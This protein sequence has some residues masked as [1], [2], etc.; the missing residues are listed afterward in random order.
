MTSTGSQP[1]DA[2]KP[3]VR[4]CGRGDGRN[5]VT[6]TRSISILACLLSVRVLAAPNVIL[7][8]ADDMGWAQT[9]Y[10]DHPV[11]ETP[12]LDAMAEN[13]LRMDRFY[14]GAPQ[15]STTRAT[16]LTGRTNDR[17]GVLTVGSSINKQEK[18]LSAA[19]RNA[20][21]TTAHFGKWHLN[22]VHGPDGHP[23]PLSDPHHPGELGFDYWLSE[24][25]QFNLNPLLSRNGTAEHIEGESS[26]ILV[27]E[28]LRFI[29]Q[30]HKQDKPAFVM[31]WYAS[32]HR[33]FEALD[34]DMEAFEGMPEASRAHHG[35][36]IAMDR[37]V[38]ALRQGLR[39]L[40]IAGNTLVWFTS[41][42]GGLPTF[43]VTRASSG[44][45]LP[46][47]LPDS[48]G[49]LRGFKSSFYEG[50]IRVPGIVEWPGHV[51]PRISNFPASTLDM[52]PTLI[53]V[54]GLDVGDINEVHDGTSLVPVFD[55]EPARRSQPM[56]FRVLGQFGWLDNDYK[57]I[58]YRDYDKALL[59]GVWDKE[60]FDSLT[61]EW[62]LYNVVDDP[63][64][65]DNLIARH[66]EIAA[67]MKAE[68]AAWNESVDRSTE[69]ADYPEG[70][71]LP[72]G[73][74]EPE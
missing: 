28:A 33:P 20:G 19:F 4:W 48:T 27:D 66:P 26:E 50:G 52:F 73:R 43:S 36:I 38:G 56:G 68:L 51:K 53:E 42:N 39:D 40:G 7:V 34:E 5:P 16:V 57:L 15:C 71:V 23:L 10:Y 72:S 6:P 31:I 14:S 47:V 18:T 3:H 37:S 74:D 63:S 12:N 1:P 55:A 60:I 41:D 67:R 13:G 62:E 17:T 49:H 61:Q 58:Y 64:E 44:E 21:Y 70:R 45:E 65:Q 30:A 69:G 54:A 2:R 8:M 32:P 35:E 9:G 46:G 25:N 29:E 59:D 22:T 24:T 11:L